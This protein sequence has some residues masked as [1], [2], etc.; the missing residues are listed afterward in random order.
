MNLTVQSPKCRWLEWVE[1]SVFEGSLEEFMKRPYGLYLDR[2]PQ[3]FQQKY[4]AQ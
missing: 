2:N 1:R 4:V 3:L